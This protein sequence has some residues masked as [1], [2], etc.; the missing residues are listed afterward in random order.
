MRQTDCSIFIVRVQKLV[1][2]VDS[3]EKKADGAIPSIDPIKYLFYGKTTRI[4]YLYQNEPDFAVY[5][6]IKEFV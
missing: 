6:K 1:K 2:W 5:R 4:D 3:V